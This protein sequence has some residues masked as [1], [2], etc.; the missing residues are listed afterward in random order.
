MRVTV[1]VTAQAARRRLLPAVVIPRWVRTLVAVVGLVAAAA[2]GAIALGSRGRDRGLSATRSSATVAGADRDVALFGLRVD[3]PRLAIVSPDGEY[4][5]ADYEMTTPCGSYGNHV[6]LV[7]HRVRGAWVQAF[8]RI[9]WSCPTR[10]LPARIAIELQLCPGASGP[11]A[12][13]PQRPPY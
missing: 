1:V 13:R 3:C 9:G 8:V 5:R 12:G 7:L 6:T 4:A 11:P 2:A 10:G